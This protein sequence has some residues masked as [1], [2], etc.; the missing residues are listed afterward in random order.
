MAWLGSRTREDMKFLLD[1]INLVNGQA[2]VLPK[3]QVPQNTKH[4][5]TPAIFP[6]KFGKLP[7]LSPA[8]LSPRNLYNCTEFQESRHKLELL[9]NLTMFKLLN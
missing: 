3:I 2:P 4:T 5:K 6:G 7:L 1:G 8:P 9:P